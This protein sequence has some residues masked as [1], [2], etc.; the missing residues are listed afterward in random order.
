MAVPSICSI[1]L[2]RAYFLYFFNVNQIMKD[3][4]QRK[5]TRLQNFNYSEYRVYYVTICTKDRNSFFGGIINKKMKLSKI[6]KVAEKCWLEIPDHFLEIELMDF[7]IM[8]DHLHGILKIQRSNKRNS[9]GCSLQPR[10]HQRLPVIIGSFKSSVTRI[11]KQLD[12]YEYFAWQK[13]YHDRI[14]RNNDELKTITKYI[15]TNPL[16]WSP[17]EHTDIF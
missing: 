15:K 6:G 2:N 13:S 1:Y 16:T 4:P 9:H 11:V 17:D 7:V 8:P 3:F 5:P 12:G 10:N 14:I